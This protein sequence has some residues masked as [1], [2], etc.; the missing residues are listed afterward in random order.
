MLDIYTYGNSGCH[1]YLAFL[2]NELDNPKIIRYASSTLTEYNKRMKA[3][4]DKYVLELVC[5]AYLAKCT[6][7]RFPGTIQSVMKNCIVTGYK[8]RIRSVNRSTN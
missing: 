6:P 4:S 3:I 5:N 8:E 2:L 7:E 1:T